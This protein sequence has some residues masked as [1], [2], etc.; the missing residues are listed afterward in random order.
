[1]RWGSSRHPAAAA[2]YACTSRLCLFYFY[3]YLYKYKQLLSAYA[4]V[5]H[6]PS[7]FRLYNYRPNPDAGDPLSS[8]V[9]LGFQQLLV[10]SVLQR[11]QRAPGS[12]A[13][14]SRPSGGQATSCPDPLIHQQQR[15]EKRQRQQLL[16]RKRL[17][18][19]KSTWE[20]PE[21]ERSQWS[22]QQ[23]A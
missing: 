12:L 10:A 14:T 22:L 8:C 20:A 15:Q 19:R 1:M 17:S 23:L 9:I 16:Q 2:P 18:T 3:F 4:A 13:S 6:A 11:Q 21:A 5:G 7:F